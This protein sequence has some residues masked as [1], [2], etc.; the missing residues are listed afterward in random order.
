M[1]EESAQIESRPGAFMGRLLADL[2]FDGDCVSR[3]DLNRVVELFFD[4]GVSMDVCNHPVNSTPV[5]FFLN[6]MRKL[7]KKVAVKDHQLWSELGGITKN[8]TEALRLVNEI[9]ANVVS[10]T[11]FGLIPPSFIDQ[12][13]L[14]G[15]FLKPSEYWDTPKRKEEV[16]SIGNLRLFSNDRVNGFLFIAPA[17]VDE[18]ISFIEGDLDVSEEVGVR[19]ISLRQSHC[20]VSE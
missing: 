17:S 1:K 18:L 16:G 5:D 10:S 2:Y 13:K 7:S 8:P 19:I 4:L 3:K 12:L 6:K 9:G 15:G 14:M 11:I 20:R